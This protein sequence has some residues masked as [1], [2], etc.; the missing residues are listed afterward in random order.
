MLSKA[1]KGLLYKFSVLTS[2]LSIQTKTIFVYYSNSIHTC[3]LSIYFKSGFVAIKVNTRAL[4][5]LPSLKFV[6]RL[7][8]AY[9]LWS[10]CHS[11]SCPFLPDVSL[12]PLTLYIINP[13]QKQKLQNKYHFPFTEVLLEIKEKT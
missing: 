12:N 9:P 6:S 11:Q 5:Q 7:F 8:S 2:T 1:Y 3:L 10:Y 4:F 13:N